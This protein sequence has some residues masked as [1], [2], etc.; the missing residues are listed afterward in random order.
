MLATLK[1]NWFLIGIV[2]VICFAKIAPYVGAKG[3]TVTI[4]KEHRPDRSLNIA[5]LEQTVSELYI[6]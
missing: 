5:N 2:L 4:A 6:T 3:G 1:K